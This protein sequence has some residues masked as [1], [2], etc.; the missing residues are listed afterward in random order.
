ML[1]VVRARIALARGDGESALADS[2]RALRAAGDSQFLLPALATRARVLLEAGG[3]D[4]G[5]LADELLAAARG[6]AVEFGSYWADLAATL[7][8]LGRQA[9]LL[10]SAAQVRTA[11]RWVDA[12]EALATGDF[13]LAAEIYGEIGSQPDAAWARSRAAAAV[14]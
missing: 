5:E 4:A 10:A 2:E 1:R 3:G 11:P 12:A 9:D 7:L 8:G 13:A 14:S 6:D